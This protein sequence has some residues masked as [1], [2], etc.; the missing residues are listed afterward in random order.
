MIIALVALSTSCSDSFLTDN[1]TQS[2]GFYK[3]TNSNDLE[4]MIAGSYWK[5]S[6]DGGWAGFQSNQQIPFVFMS[7]EGELESVSNPD[8]EE[9]NWYTDRNTS[10]RNYWLVNPFW[11]AGYGTLAI[12]N[13]AL[14]A[15]ADNRSNFEGP[16]LNRQLGEAYFLRAL[17]YF[18][19]VKVFGKPY[20]EEGS[21]NNQS[22][23]IILYDKAVEGPKDYKAL[24]TVDDAY[25]LIVSDVEQAVSLL[26]ETPDA[27]NS[28]TAYMTGKTRATKDAA[29]FLAA[30]IYFQMHNYSKA[31]EYCSQVL[32]KNKYTLDQD[33]INAWKLKGYTDDAN[34]VIWLYNNSNSQVQWKCPIQGR[35]FGYGNQG[36]CDADGNLT[37]WNT[38]QRMSV[39]PG[40]LKMIGWDD[41]NVA[42]KDKRY[43]QLFVDIPAGGDTNR[44]TYQVLQNRK[45]WP[46]KWYRV[47]AQSWP[48]GSSTSYPWFRSS[49]LYLTRAWC[50]LKLG[51]ASGAVQ[52]YNVVAKRAWDEKVAG[53][54]YQM[55]TSVTEQDI[56]NQ[57][58]IE[59]MFEGDR[60]F[61]LE[62]TK[63]DI[64]SQEL[65]SDSKYGSVHKGISWKSISFQ[66]PQ[67]EAD[68][69]PLVE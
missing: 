29:R 69:N 48:G 19:L 61:Y 56:D 60:V 40:V 8:T 3:P 41:I 17:V 50:R 27:S 22:L 1:G 25:K 45:I 5:L 58:M 4:L 43:S 66:V 13:N 37:S 12:V 21:E 26:P 64:P 63:R 11:T 44:P 20:D 9:Q 57:R 67:I 51:D 7:D 55:K 16:M 49:E 36:Y 14:Q 38:G 15:V 28:T 32:D 62:A 18:E 24:S 23:S 2:A 34:E 54:P 65:S 10:N 33:P 31:A 42:K 30:R 53:I 35:Y 59:M 68:A 52:D 46:D 47:Y 6:G 39:A